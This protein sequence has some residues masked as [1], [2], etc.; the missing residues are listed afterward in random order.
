MPRKENGGEQS[1]PLAW[2]KEIAIEE[3]STIANITLGEKIRDGS[4]VIEL[5][6]ICNPQECETIRDYC[7]RR[8]VC[9]EQLAMLDESLAL[10]Q[11]GLVRLPTIQAATRAQ[12]TDTT[13]AEPLA[14]EIDDL[15][16]DILL[17]V[18]ALIDEKIPSIVVELFSDEEESESAKNCPATISSTSLV[19]QMKSQTRLDY[20]RREPAINV[21]TNGGEFQKHKDAQS[22]TILVPLSSPETHF[23][24]GGTG[25]WSEHELP[26]SSNDYNF[27]HFPSFAGDQASNEAPPIV[28]LRPPAGTALLFGGSVTH[29]GIPVGDQG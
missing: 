22:L 7:C 10:N 12:E 25:F 23:Q 29:A 15:C 13:C 1:S 28:I 5:P 8:A 3:S 2:M 26:D 19:E 18:A 16:Q 20:T 17:R 4:I 24:E 21:Y 11:V 27:D 6:D 14:V 9:D